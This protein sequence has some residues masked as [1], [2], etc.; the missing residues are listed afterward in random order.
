VKRVLVVCYSQTGQLKRCAQSLAAPLADSG[1]VQVDFVELVPRTPYPFPWGLR[2]FLSVF[3]ESVLG[4]PPTIAPAAVD[5]A[6]RYDLV[7]LAYTVWYLSP[8]PPVVAFLAS[9]QAQVLQGAPVVALCACRNMWQRAWVE[10]KRLVSARGGRIVDHVVRVDQGPDWSTF[11]T[12]PRWLIA[13]KKE[14]GPFPP[15]GVSEQAIAE[16]RTPG[17]RLLEALRSGPIERSV[18]AG[19]GLEV[20]EVRRRY[21]LPEMAAKRVFGL[22]ARLMRAAGPSLAYPVGLAWFAW[23][24]CSLPLAIPLALTGEILRIA[25]VRWYRERIEELAQPS[26]GPVR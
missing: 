20:M 13:G 2:R 9:P 1:E 3:P 14:G 18:F 21:L 26:G 24:A 23:L 5:P 12:T 16:L 15:A 8:A 11:Y 22:W 6:A 4:E 7:I 10:L 17:L 25:G 19:S